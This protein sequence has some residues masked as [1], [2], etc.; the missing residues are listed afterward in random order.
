MNETVFE[1]KDGRPLGNLSLTSA[2][3]RMPTREEAQEEAR[4]Q[5]EDIKKF[6]KTRV[7]KEVKG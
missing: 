6:L 5:C 7:N 4:S 3:G 2:L 1:W